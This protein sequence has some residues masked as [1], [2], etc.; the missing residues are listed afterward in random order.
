MSSTEER[1]SHFDGSCHQTHWCRAGRTCTALWVASALQLCMLKEWEVQQ[2][3]W[4]KHLYSTCQVL[5]CTV[6]S[7]R[8][9]ALCRMLVLSC[10]P[11]FF[12][13][14][15]HESVLRVWLEL[16][17]VFFY[18]PCPQLLLQLLSWLYNPLFPH[19]CCL[20]LSVSLFLTYSL[21]NLCHISQPTSLIY[22]TFLWTEISSY[23]K[24]NRKKVLDTKAFI[25]AIF[26]VCELRRYALEDCWRLFVLTMTL[27]NH[28]QWKWLPV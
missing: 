8:A 9:P 6:S 13:Y 15:L 25:W 11:R 26:R 16:S 17:E 22:K 20:C 1:K 19:F 24:L 27:L 14:F 21:I 7:K 10:P 28:I 23:I 18:N 3:V 12:F 5:S 2:S 4:R